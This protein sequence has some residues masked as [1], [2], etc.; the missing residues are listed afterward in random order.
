[1]RALGVY[2]EHLRDGRS[3]LAQREKEAQRELGRYG[4]GRREDEDG[5]R[6][7]KE[8]VMREVAR[9]YG[10]MGKEVE[11]VRRDLERLKGK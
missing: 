3:R 8:K 4:V 9:V 10:E 6:A 1:M 5:D 7:G 11:E 2:A